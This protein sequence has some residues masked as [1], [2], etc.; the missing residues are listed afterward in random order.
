MQFHKHPSH[1]IASLE[2]DGVEIYISPLYRK[3]SAF[4]CDSNNQITEKI[5]THLS[6]VT[7]ILA[8]SKPNRI[9]SIKSKYIN[10]ATAN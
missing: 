7:P 4:E 3:K 8:A 10:L 1:K 5:S 2:T 6:T 9:P